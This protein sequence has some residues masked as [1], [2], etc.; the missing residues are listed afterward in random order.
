MSI[1]V[2]G[3]GTAVAV[4]FTVTEKLSIPPSLQRGAQ[5][6]EIDADENRTPNWIG[7]PLE[8]KSG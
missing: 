4:K 8:V 2:D 3:S 1:K 6:P 5:P 7:A